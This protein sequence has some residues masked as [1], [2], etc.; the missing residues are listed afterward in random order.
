VYD[1]SGRVLCCDSRE[2]GAR[3]KSKKIRTSSHRCEL[4]MNDARRSPMTPG[5]KALIHWLSRVKYYCTHRL[6]VM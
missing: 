6:D 1:S 4:I 2:V 5:K 3:R